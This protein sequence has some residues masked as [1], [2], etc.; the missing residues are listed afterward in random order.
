MAFFFLSNIVYSCKAY[1]R[2][3]ARSFA[4]VRAQVGITLIGT[5][6]AVADVIIGWQIGRCFLFFFVKHKR[7]HYKPL[8]RYCYTCM[9]AHSVEYY[10]IMLCAA[11]CAGHA[12]YVGARGRQRDRITL[13]F[14]TGEGEEIRKIREKLTISKIIVAANAS[15]G[16]LGR[17]IT[18]LIYSVTREFIFYIIYCCVG[19]RCV[20]FNRTYSIV[21]IITRRRN[22]V[23]FFPLLVL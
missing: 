17:C 8:K 3:R 4:Y 5:R 21:P 22:Y 1:T 7:T 2:A 23:F 11:L 18:Y 20:L 9:G 19:A 16:A 14:I 12:C 10:N 13:I 15:N 6:Q